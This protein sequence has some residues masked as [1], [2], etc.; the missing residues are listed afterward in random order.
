[1]FFFQDSYDEPSPAAE[2]RPTENFGKYLEIMLNMIDKNDEYLGMVARDEIYQVV[3][4][5]L[6]ELLKN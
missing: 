6:A 1:M 4:E 2:N 3:A 5:A